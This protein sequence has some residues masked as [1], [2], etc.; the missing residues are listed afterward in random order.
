MGRLRGIRGFFRSGASPFS[1]FGLISL[2]PGVPAAC[3]LC[4][5]RVSL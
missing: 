3:G 4:G 5:Q 2:L 1:Y